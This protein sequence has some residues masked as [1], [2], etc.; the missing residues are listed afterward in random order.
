MP[1]PTVARLTSP[2]QLVAALPL[3]LGYTPTESL[4]VACCHEPRG[5]IGLTLRFDLPAAA[6]EQ[7]LAAEVARR[8]RHQRATR[9]V[10]AVFT[11]DPDGPERARR[12][13]VRRVQQE[14]PD[15]VLT[16]AVL[17]REGR[18]FSYVC[19]VADCC[20]PEGRPVA[21]AHADA[22]VRLLEAEQV[23]R[24]QVVL[25]DRAELE[26][27]LSGPQLFAEHEALQRCEAACQELADAVSSGT[28]AQY[29]QRL[30]A[31]WQGALDAF[32]APPAHVAPEEAA[33]LAV[34]LADRWLRD[35]LAAEDDVTAMLA[36][37][38]ELCRRTPAPY[39]APVCTLLAWLTY[40]EGGGAAVTILL[41]RALASDPSY[42]LALLL[43]EVVL[44]QVPPAK[45]R[46]VTQQAFG[47]VSRARRVRRA[48]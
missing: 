5:R 1:K 3:W 15:L 22:P 32:S 21:T 17:V 48:G 27:L 25:R 26:A 33:A 38:E 20:P 7:A 35:Q 10:L 29:R 39:D 16:E 47:R 31:R 41:D 4:V 6:D 45:L 43:Q 34:S 44:G 11:A 9:I 30:L 42:S 36:L 24:G 19:E 40:C 23:L 8:V 14:L 2:A 46:A 13:L 37:L 12:A 18:F 28:R